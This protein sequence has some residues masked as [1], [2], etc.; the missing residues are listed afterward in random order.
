MKPKQLLY[1]DGKVL[2]KGV[3]QASSRS[4]EPILCL[5][6]QD[7]IKF[8][9]VSGLRLVVSWEIKLYHSVPL[10]LAFVIPPLIAQLLSSEAVR[11]QAKVEIAVQGDNVALRL[12][13]Q[14]GHCQIHW[15]SDLASFSAPIQFSDLIKV[16]DALLEVPYIS[17]SDAIHKAVAKLVRLEAKGEINRNKLAILIDL[18]LGRLSVNSQEIIA[19]ESSRYY[20]DPRLVIRALEFIKEQTVRVGITPLKLAKRAYLSLWAKQDDWTVHCSLLSIGMD[21][22]KLY[23]LQPGRNR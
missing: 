17:F 7:T 6:K 18:D 14:L 23:P 10:Y 5:V 20:F 8:V 15:E 3:R 9:A 21:T 16:P 4:E 22:Q 2:W 12:V 13:D 19:A 1:M 11:D